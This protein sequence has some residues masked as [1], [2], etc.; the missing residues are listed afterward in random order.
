MKKTRLIHILA[1]MSILIGLVSG[2][3]AS[4][5][6]EKAVLCT[7]VLT[8]GE[9]KTISD[10][11]APDIKTIYCSV[12]L[13]SVSTKSSVK[14]VWY[15]VKSEEAN[16]V[17]TLLGEGTIKAGTPY[18]VVS[19]TRGDKLLP[20]GDYTVKL[21][22]DEKFIQAVPFKIAGEAAASAAT[23]S[24]A[25]LC[26]S[27]DFSTDKPIDKVDVFPDDASAIA[28]S[29]KVNNADFD[30]TVKAS[31]TYV[32]GDTENLKGKTIANPATKVEGREYIA[33]SIGMP[34]GKKFPVGEWKL[35]LFV[36]DKEQVTM[37]FKV[38]EAASIKWPYISEMAVYATGVSDNQTVALTTPFSVD[39]KEINFQAKTYNAPSDTDVS[40]QW[41][42]AQSTD[43]VFSDKLLNEDKILIQ[44]T[45]PVIDVLKTKSDPFVKGEYLVKL[46][47]G[48]TEYAVI[49]FSIR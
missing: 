28:C 13:S 22:Y 47:T 20:K 6:I 48:G 40:I 11:F 5:P 17:D 12:K 46:L 39:V 15:V 1:I 16:L 45:E 8:T 9:P 24:E 18:V 19:F 36:G 14:G 34:A 30:T 44:G 2:C 27:I 38:V 31:W 21:Y 26:T 49:P 23:L 32:S 29:V 4:T 43:G 42:L 41:W 3:Q 33:F 7:D 35:S 10:T 37:P 25:T